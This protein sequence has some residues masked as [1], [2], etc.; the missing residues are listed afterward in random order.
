M[1]NS[2]THFTNSTARP[3][4]MWDVSV[5]PAGSVNRHLIDTLSYSSGYEGSP[6][7]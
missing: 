4:D 1:I 3:A 6:T 5:Y 2:I 7:G